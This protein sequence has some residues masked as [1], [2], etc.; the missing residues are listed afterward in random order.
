VH[1]DDGRT[2]DMFATESDDDRVVIRIRAT[3]RQVD[4]RPWMRCMAGWATDPEVATLTDR[5]FRAWCYILDYLT[6][7]GSHTG[8]LPTDRD[9]LRAVM[10]VGRE[11]TLDKVLLGL[12]RSRLVVPCGRITFLF[13]SSSDQV[14]SS[15]PQVGTLIVRKWA[16]LQGWSAV[17]LPSPPL[18]SSSSSPSSPTEPGQILDREELH[19]VPPPNADPIDKPLH[20]PDGVPHG[21]P[22]WPIRWYMERWQELVE[23]F[24]YSKLDRSVPL[25][26]GTADGPCDWRFVVG[27]LAAKWTAIEEAAQARAKPRRTPATKQ[28]ARTWWQR[29]CSDIQGGAPTDMTWGDL[30]AGVSRARALVPPAEYERGRTEFDTAVREQRSRLWGDG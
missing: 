18:L 29:V 15:L 25:P 28:T 22:A 19:L 5:E 21:F 11:A 20:V 12:A 30:R 13:E 27:W 14:E 1:D 8:L 26:D 10:R 4:R 16:E 17:S 6:A 3:R 23:A 7:R 9:E 2:Q 24:A